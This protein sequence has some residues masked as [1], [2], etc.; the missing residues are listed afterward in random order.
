MVFLI[1]GFILILSTFNIIA[2]ITMLLFDKQ[3]DIKTLISMG[4]TQQF[5]QRIFFLEGLFINLLGGILGISIG[6]GVCYLQ[7]KLHFVELQNSVID[8]WPIEIELE[9]LVMVFSTVVII[10]IVSSYLPVKYLIRKQFSQ[11]F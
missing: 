10:G 1:L 11:S 2:S 7:V 4:A 3:K 9:D 6:L 8:Y 5:I